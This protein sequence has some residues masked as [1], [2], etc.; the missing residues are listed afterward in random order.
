LLTDK[1]FFDML[2]AI[3]ADYA[4]Q[5]FSTQAVQALAEK[6]MPASANVEGTGS[7]DWFFLQWVYDTG[8]PH[9]QLRTRIERLDP[10]RYRIRGTITQRGV[11]DTFIMPV[12]LYASSRGRLQFLGRVV[13]TGPETSFEYVVSSRPERILLDPHQTILCVVE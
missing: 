4:Q 9:Y 8:I 12:P 3:V 2:Q 5:P 10:Q 13:V 11:P 1:A 6:G 7:L